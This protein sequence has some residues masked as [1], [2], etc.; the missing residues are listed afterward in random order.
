MAGRAV[1]G[2]NNQGVCTCACRTIDCRLIC[3]GQSVQFPCAIIVHF[4]V[5]HNDGKR[6]HFGWHNILYYIKALVFNRVKRWTLVRWSKKNIRVMPVHITRKLKIPGPYG[7]IC[8]EPFCALHIAKN[9]G[10][11]AMW[12]KI[13]NWSEKQKARHKYLLCRFLLSPQPKPKCY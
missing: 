5:V 12:W 7:K 10:S 11:G 8:A 1:S 4:D 2:A 13:N 3:H 6:N 9:F